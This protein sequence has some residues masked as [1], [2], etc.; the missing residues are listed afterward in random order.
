MKLQIQGDWMTS[1]FD[2]D[3][4]FLRR[5]PWL[6]RHVA[7]WT[8]TS[9]PCC[10]GYGSSC[11]TAQSPS[12]AAP[13][14]SCSNPVPASLAEEALPAWPLRRGACMGGQRRSGADRSI[15]RPT[16]CLHE[17]TIC[18]RVRGRCVRRA[19]LLASPL[20]GR[21]T[22]SFSRAGV[23]RAWTESGTRPVF[24]AVAGISTGA[25]IAPFAFSARVMMARA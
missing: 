3:R 19:A 18:Q 1:S 12:L 10:C 22:W 6:S 25:I 14:G 21:P 13:G 7:S 2:V 8:E 17:A 9:A 23:L 5:D 11:G 15:T 20:R 16:P 24:D 4:R